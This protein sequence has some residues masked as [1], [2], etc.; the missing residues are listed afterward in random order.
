MLAKSWRYTNPQCSPFGRHPAA[1]GS[2]SPYHGWAWCC[3]SR[4]LFRSMPVRWSYDPTLHPAVAASG[5]FVFVWVFFLFGQV[6]RCCQKWAVQAYQKAKKRLLQPVTP[7]LKGPS[8]L[9][10]TQGTSI[11]QLVVSFPC[12]G[13]F[14]S[15]PRLSPP[16]RCTILRCSTG[17]L[18]G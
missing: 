6:A 16:C 12:G 10:A 11:E 1:N 4:K 18:W 8:L 2:T 9:Q 15:W 3:F 17:P 7:I 13:R 14:W 5:C